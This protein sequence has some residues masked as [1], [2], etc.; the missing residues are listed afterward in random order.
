MLCWSARRVVF[1]GDG[2]GWMGGIELGAD[3]CRSAEKLPGLLD[4][5]FQ[6]RQP[7]LFFQA[8]Q[9]FAFTTHFLRQRQAGGEQ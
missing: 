9:F 5:A 1:R 8:G 2:D 3:V 4:V 6:C 7:G